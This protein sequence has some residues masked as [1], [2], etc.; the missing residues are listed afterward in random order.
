MRKQLCP[1][2]SIAMEQS[3]GPCINRPFLRGHD[4]GRNLSVN[5]QRKYDYCAS[6]IIGHYSSLAIV[7]R[8]RVPNILDI[9]AHARVKRYVIN[10]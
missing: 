9:V 6:M 7:D 5:G 2:F 1:T 8:I 3:S 10:G 4:R